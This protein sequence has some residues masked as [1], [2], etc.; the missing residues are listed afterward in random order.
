M[1]VLFYAGRTGWIPVVTVT[2]A[3]I[4]IGLS[5]GL[6]FTWGMPGLVAARLASAVL[7]S[8]VCWGLAWRA[9]RGLRA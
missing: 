3:V 4:S 7:R 2:S 6:T 5:A 1:N 8:A 9:V